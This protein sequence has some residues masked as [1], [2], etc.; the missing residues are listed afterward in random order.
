MYLCP[1]MPVKKDIILL[2]LASGSP[3][4]LHYPRR[5]LGLKRFT[6]FMKR[7]SRKGFE[8]SITL[9]SN[10]F[11]LATIGISLLQ[12]SNCPNCTLLDRMVATSCNA[13]VSVSVSQAIRVYPGLATGPSF[14]EGRDE[15]CSSRAKP[16]QGPSKSRKL[17][18]PQKNRAG[19]KCSNSV[20]VFFLLFFFWEIMIKWRSY[21][22][23]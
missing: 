12:V 20:V 23:K 6:A 8:I 16:L 22:I 21:V 9:W 7:A 17:L 18:V 2:F 1:T 11:W 4:N 14:A 10:E 19:V 13:S 3:F 5:L 15:V